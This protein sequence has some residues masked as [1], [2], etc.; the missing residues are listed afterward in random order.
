MVGI[1]RPG[2][3]VRIVRGIGWTLI[4]T[5]V[6]TALY[7]VY[8]L[9]F[10][11]LET[12]RA[13]VE[14]LDQWEL[15]VGSAD[16]SL[17][18]EG[19]DDDD[20]GPAEPVSPGDAYAAMWFERDG[21]RIVADDPLFVVSGTDLGTLRRGPG[22]Y[23]DTAAPGQPGNFAIAGHRTTYGAPFYHLDLLQEGDEIHVIDR[24]NRTWV[25]AF[26]EQRIVR[27][28][29]IWVVGN[30][31]FNDGATLITLTTCHPRLSAAQR[32]IVWGELIESPET[33]SD[34]T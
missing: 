3:V 17:P 15:Q 23:T 5:G 33:D 4:A 32:M 6:L 29:D 14:L 2:P 11:N 18:G 30:D 26:R 21:E 20:D 28:Q 12:N 25:Y 7:V 19:P 27:P 31:P 22:H 10:T 8:L 1:H 24:Q 16:Q 34:E 13:Q 9:F